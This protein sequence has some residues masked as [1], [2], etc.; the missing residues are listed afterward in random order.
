MAWA[1]SGFPTPPP[2]AIFTRRFTS[3]DIL[4]LLEAINVVRQNVWALQPAGFMEEAVIDVD[5]SLV[6]TLGECKAGM[7]ISYNGIW[8]YHPL[9]IS[10]AKTKEVL[11]LVDRSG[12]VPSHDG[13]VPWLD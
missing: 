6:P 9:I 10:L 5:G 12:N 2:L 1:H 13:F 4:A 8:G 3:A 11:Y 7:D